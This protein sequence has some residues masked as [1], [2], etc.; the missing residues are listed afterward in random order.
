MCSLPLPWACRRGTPD[1]RAVVRRGRPWRPPTAVGSLRGYVPHG[2]DCAASAGPAR[3][4]RHRPAGGTHSTDDRDRKQ[5]PADSAD[6]LP[7]CRDGRQ[8]SRRLIDPPHGEDE[9]TGA[10][11]GYLVAASRAAGRGRGRSGLSL[12]RRAGR[13]R[14][15]QRRRRDLAAA[16]VSSSAATLIRWLGEWRAAAGSRAAGRQGATLGVWPGHQ[17]S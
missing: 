15:G 13:C 2:R 16:S 4:P 6:R 12:P 17:H 7:R 1:A 5:R 8:L 10:E 11:I 3:W 9:L 14:T